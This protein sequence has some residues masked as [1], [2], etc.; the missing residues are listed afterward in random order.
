[1]TWLGG[2]W[3][4]VT[5]Y[6]IA[7]G[8]YLRNAIL[9]EW[10]LQSNFGLKEDRKGPTW[11]S[12]LE[13]DSVSSPLP[14]CLSPVRFS[15]NA[16]KLFEQESEKLCVRMVAVYMTGSSARCGALWELQRLFG[17]TCSDILTVLHLSRWLRYVASW[18]KLWPAVQF[19]LLFTRTMM[20]RVAVRARH[21]SVL[22]STS[23]VGPFP[24]W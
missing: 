15:W 21:F 17:E 2:T 22:V 14:P 19:T 11:G 7:G 3:Y 20:V 13:I 8:S 9:T 24:W 4:E 6:V 16:I 5:W 12:R 18:N 10:Y 23:V 1:M